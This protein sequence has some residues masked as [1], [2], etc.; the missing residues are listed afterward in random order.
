MYISNDNTN[1][2]YGIEVITDSI[3][4][5]VYTKNESIKE[6][7]ELVEKRIQ[8]ETENIKRDEKETDKIKEIITN[9]VQA[10][11]DINYIVETNKLRL[12]IDKKSGIC[13]WYDKAVG[14]RILREGKKELIE[15]VVM[16]YLV[17]GDKAIIKRVKTVD[18]ERNFIQNLEQVAGESAYSAKMYFEWE[19]NEG[20]YG[21]G[22]GEE[23]IYNYRGHTQYL[24]QHNM[25]IPM[26]CFVSSNRYGIFVDCGSLMTFHDEKDGS[27]LSLDTVDQIDYYFMAGDSMDN[28]IS[29]YRYLTGDAV[30]LPKWAFG[31]V[32]SK[33]AYL[34]QEELVDTVAQYR[35]RNV[36]I[37]CI[38]QD[39]WTWEEGNWGEK[40]VDKKRYP[41]LK[42]AMD[43]IHD[44]HVHTMVS[45]WPNMNQGGENYTEMF[46]AGHMLA[47]LSTYD[48]F[49]E[50]AREIYFKQADKE[51]FS[52][53]FDAW[54]CDSTEPFSGPDWNGEIKRE[55]LDRFMLVGEEHK[56]YLG[57]K[58]ANIF[59][60]M[61]A[62]GIYENQRK[63]TDEK[64]VLNLTRSGYSSIQ[65]YGTVLWSGDTCATWDNFQIQ[66][67]EGLNMALSGMPYWTLDIGAFFTVKEKWENRGCNCS[68]DSSMKWFWQGDYEDGVNDFAYR[69]LYTRWLQMGTFLPMMRSHGT[70]TPR[71]I[72]HFGEKGEIFYDAIEKFI[73]LRYTL[74]PY[75]YSIAADVHFHQG[76]MLRSLLFDYLEDENVRNISDEFMFGPYILV[77][78]VTKPMYYDRG[79]KE[80]TKEKEWICYLPKGNGWYDFW[81]RQH[82]AGGQ[83]VCVDAN[84]DKIPLFIKEGAII[85][86][87]KGIQYADE[88]KN[89]P[90]EILVYPGADGS[91]L[92][93]EDEGD[94]Y[95]FEKGNYA[96][97]LFTWDEKSRALHIGKTEGEYPGM[98]SGQEYKIIVI[99]E[100]KA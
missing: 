29:G 56:K 78:P 46:E 98:C 65:K 37:D 90:I 58:R 20:I 99:E 84:I 3:F 63:K 49:N 71:E 66:I 92:L 38:V 82:Y 95:N 76:T 97:T 44:M 28:I 19:E 41:N 85:P 36:P 94:N 51:L 72:W 48:A 50:E 43:K 67:T 2:K 15:K 100:N 64:R 26:P 79:N 23:G 93:Y 30:M 24:Y 59:A 31:Y 27:Y 7:S 45:I 68:Q 9:T 42:D 18:G 60:V 13:T 10:E 32:Q 87:S 70:D 69:E 39:W 77:C 80:L 11:N 8:E 12:E 21:L 88:K 1:G 55:P 4:R 53:G 34:K 61:H 22:Q 96:V 35:R 14:K 40:L 54:W 83:Y 25:R 57:A 17:K 81:T 16:N 74:M 47:D 73:N 91:F 5:V 33:E 86:T 52:G 62:K 89:E 75:I 6:P